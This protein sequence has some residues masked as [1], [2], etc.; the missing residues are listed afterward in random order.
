MHKLGKIKKINGKKFRAVHY[1]FSKKLAQKKAQYVRDHHEG[2]GKE[3]QSESDEAVYEPYDVPGSEADFESDYEEAMEDREHAEEVEEPVYYGSEETGA[4]IDRAIERQKEKQRERVEVVPPE[5]EPEPEPAPSKGYGEAIFLYIN[6]G[7]GKYTL[8]DHPFD[9]KAEAAKYAKEIYPDTKYKAMTETEVKAY[10]AKL[11][12]RAERVEKVKEGAKKAGEEIG[13]AG[14]YV[15]RGLKRIATPVGRASYDVARS[16]GMTREQMEPR[17]K[18]AWGVPPYEQQPVGRPPIY[19]DRYPPLTKYGAP[20]RPI[21]T[22][23]FEP[24]RAPPSYEKEIRRTQEEEKAY[25]ESYRP[26]FNFQ[27]PPV[28]RTGFHIPAGGGVFGSRIRQP[29][30]QSFEPVSRT[31]PRTPFKPM[32]FNFGGGMHMARMH[33]AGRP[34]GWQPGRQYQPPQEEPSKKRFKKKKIKKSKKKSK[35]KKGKK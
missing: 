2:R 29:E 13:E 32:K 23:N 8:V 28:R 22:P 18:Q 24:A 17:I 27:Q 30:R 26:R 16:H 35:K 10:M 21:R 31:P 19:R 15:G 11:E 9:S 12:K 14:R 3:Y 7:I 25:R 33:Y 5:P 6:T 34:P 4:A 1:S 20:S